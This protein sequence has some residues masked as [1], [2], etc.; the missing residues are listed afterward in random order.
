MRRGTF[1]FLFKKRK[2]LSN[3]IGIWSGFNANLVGYKLLIVSC[4][5]N[6]IIQKLFEDSLYFDCIVEK[7]LVPNVIIRKIDKDNVVLHKEHYLR[8]NC[9]DSKKLKITSE[10]VKGIKTSD[11]IVVSLQAQY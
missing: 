3:I 1:Y 9:E 8:S 4:T 7:E 10:C 6:G 5:K 11:T 2:L